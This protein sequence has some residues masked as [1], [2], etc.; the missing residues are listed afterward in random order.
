MT[1]KVFEIIANKLQAMNN[2]LEKGNTEW[3]DKHQDSIKSIVSET[4]PHGSGFDSGTKLNFDESKP[5]RLVFDTGFHHMN[6][7]GYYDGWTEHK[8]IVTPSLVY[9]FTLRVTGR[10]KREI[11]DYIGECFHQCLNAEIVE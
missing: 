10:D 6:D 7:G 9:G 5:E 4:F 8:V 2:C 3:F 11:K 1:R